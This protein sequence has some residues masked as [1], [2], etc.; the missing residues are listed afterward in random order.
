M[1]KCVYF[2]YLLTCFRRISIKRARH[3][4]LSRRLD[5]FKCRL[6]FL[7]CF[8]AKRRIHSS[9]PGEK[10]VMVLPATTWLAKPWDWGATPTESRA[11]LVIKRSSA[12]YAVLNSVCPTQNKQAAIW[13]AISTDNI[14]RQ[15]Y[16]KYKTSRG[17]GILQAN[18]YTLTAPFR[19]Y[20]VLQGF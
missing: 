14:C 4:S 3:F 20:V 8:H 1:H 10:A 18:E 12:T 2:M 9:R 11:Y 5:E 16:G 17:C 7:N 6:G 19:W 15:M 13:L